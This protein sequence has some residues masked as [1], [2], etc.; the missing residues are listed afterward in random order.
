[1]NLRRLL[2]LSLVALLS[3]CLVFAQLNGPAQHA[4]GMQGALR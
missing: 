2:L 4:Y 1:M 3:P